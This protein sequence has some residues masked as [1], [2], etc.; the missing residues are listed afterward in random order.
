MLENRLKDDGK[1]STKSNHPRR[2]QLKKILCYSSRSDTCLRVFFVSAVLVP[3]NP[4]C[5]FHSFLNYVSQVLATSPFGTLSTRIIPNEA[6][7][8]N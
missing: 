4:N 2:K 6:G 1:D 8:R 7:G 5:A 3:N